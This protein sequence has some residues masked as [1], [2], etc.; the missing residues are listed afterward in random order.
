MVLWDEIGSAPLMAA[1]YSAQ[2]QELGLAVQ[3]P[4]PAH[5]CI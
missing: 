5:G 4:H 3:A 1:R 2:S